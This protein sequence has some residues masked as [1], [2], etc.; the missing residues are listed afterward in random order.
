AGG[1]RSDSV[2]GPGEITGGDIFNTLPFPNTV[3]SL[4]LTG[5]ELVET[6]ESQVVTLESETGQ[7][8]GEEIS[9]QTSGLRFEWVPHD[10]A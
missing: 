3:I 6:L 9:Q 7:N 2:Y 1:I 10:D 8:F 5:E 4:E